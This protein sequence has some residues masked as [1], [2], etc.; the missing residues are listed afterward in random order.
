MKTISLVSTVILV[1]FIAFVGTVEAQ[2]PKEGTSSYTAIFAGTYKAV[3]TGPDEFQMT[4]EHT[5]A[6]LSDTGEGIFHMA[7][8]HCM[9]SQYVVKG[10][11]DNDSGFCYL[12][13]PDGDKAFFTY[14]ATGN[15]RTGGKQI[16]TFVGGTGKLTG[17]QGS[18]EA[19][20]FPLRASG[21][22]GTPYQGPYQGLTKSKGQYKLP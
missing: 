3:G 18:S 11:Y 2:I 6:M 20:R 9:G 14:K 13:R 17:L 15:I 22:P 5:G 4:Y 7:T 16:N 1:L 21:P 10:N 8:L 12:T 19:T